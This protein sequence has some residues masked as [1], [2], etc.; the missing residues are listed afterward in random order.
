[1][2]MYSRVI[3]VV[4]PKRVRLRAAEAESKACAKELRGKQKVLRGVEET[5][6]ALSGQL[7]L[8]Q[9][10]LAGLQA[11]VHTATNKLRIVILGLGAARQKM[12]LE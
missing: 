10:E 6:A 11:Q 12:A 5:L 9:A 3:K 1:M 7:A 2:D 4:G 8:Q